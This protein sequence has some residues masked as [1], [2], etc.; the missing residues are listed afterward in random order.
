MM[1]LAHSGLVRGKVAPSARPGWGAIPWAGRRGEGGGRWMGSAEGGAGCRRPCEG[2]RWRRVS[3]AL[4][5]SGRRRGRLRRSGG[6]EAG[7]GV[8]QPGPP[9]SSLLPSPRPVGRGPAAAT[10]PAGRACSAG[11]GGGKCSA[12]GGRSGGGGEGPAPASPRGSAA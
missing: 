7:V 3:Q 2:G 9:R 11:G 10:C 8:G 1:A 5:G 4:A 12:S 6:R